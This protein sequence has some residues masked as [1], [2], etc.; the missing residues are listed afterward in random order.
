[1]SWF[2]AEQWRRFPHQASV[3]CGFN[4]TNYFKIGLYIHFVKTYM[5]SVYFYLSQ[6]ITNDWIVHAIRQ[7]FYRTAR[8]IPTHGPIEFT[9]GPTTLW[10]RILISTPYEFIGVFSYVESLHNFQIGMLDCSAKPLC[11]FFTRFT[12]TLPKSIS[13]SR[14]ARDFNA[15]L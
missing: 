1:M 12:K 13:W 5:Y 14:K 8:P 4:I 10:S 3:V 9:I 2:S 6:S 7:P 11:K 15:P